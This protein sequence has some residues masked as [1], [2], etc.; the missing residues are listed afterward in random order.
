MAARKLA[1]ALAGGNC[2][3]LKPAEQTSLGISMLMEE[4]GDLLPPACSMW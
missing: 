1:P 2:V 4:I 3:V